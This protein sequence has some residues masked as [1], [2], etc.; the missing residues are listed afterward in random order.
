MG[1]NLDSTQ[2]ERQLSREIATVKLKLAELHCAVYVIEIFM[3]LE[4]EAELTI[5]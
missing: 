2:T 1:T 4:D 5:A 3:L